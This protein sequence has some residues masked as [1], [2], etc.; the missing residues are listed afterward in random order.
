MSI[1]KAERTGDMV[2]GVGL[3]PSKHKALNSNP[4]TAEREINYGIKDDTV[5][6]KERHMD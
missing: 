4:N 6:E 3:L 1:G 5:L 2:P